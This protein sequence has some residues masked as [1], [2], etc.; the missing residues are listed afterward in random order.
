MID[1]VKVKVAELKEQYEAMKASLP[2]MAKT[3]DEYIYE[4]FMKTCVHP[5][6]FIPEEWPEEEEKKPRKERKGN[7]TLRPDKSM[8]TFKAPVCKGIYKDSKKNG[9]AKPSL[10][11]TT[12]KTLIALTEHNK[13]AKEDE[14]FEYVP[15]TIM[16][17]GKERK[18]LPFGKDFFHSGDVGALQVRPTA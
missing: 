18:R 14:R 7:P 9:E 15:Q 6:E 13:T 17:M 3:E 8:I 4:R 1:F 10:P 5:I 11:L 16:L 2:N 12:D